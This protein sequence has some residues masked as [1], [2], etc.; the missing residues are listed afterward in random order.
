MRL[1]ILY[2]KNKK[3]DELLIRQLTEKIIHRGPDDTGYFIK[4]N[5]AFGFDRLSI[6]DL[7]GGNQH[8]KRKI[9]QLYLMAKY[10]II[11]N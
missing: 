10:I 11:K 8:L 6:I 7:E 9:E 2:Y 5:I 3:A 1:Y 4:N